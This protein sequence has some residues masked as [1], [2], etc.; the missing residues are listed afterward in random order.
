MTNSPEPFSIS[1]VECPVCGCINEYAD[2]RPLSYR[3]TGSDTDFHPLGRVWHNAAYQTY[4]PLWFF[5]ATCGKCFYTREL[6]NEFKGWGQDAWLLLALA[7]RDDA[8]RQDVPVDRR[9][10]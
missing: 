6:N 3:D 1:K 7:E 8:D 4:D 10:R 2:V 5:M 9:H